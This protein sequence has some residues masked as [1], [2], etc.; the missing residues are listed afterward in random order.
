MNTIEETTLNAYVDGELEPDMQKQVLNA[1]E[2]DPQVR[3]QVCRLRRAKDWM[4]TGFAEVVPR[5]HRL[6]T[7]HR[8][9]PRCG[10]TIAASLLALAIGFGGGLL[11][12]MCAGDGTYAAA[13]RQDPNRVVLH[14]GDSDPTHFE[15]TL[16]YAEH[17]L[18]EN[19]ERGAR[20]EVVA[21]AGGID[22]VRSG[23]SPYED[24]IRA[25]RAR[26]PNLHFFACMN[27]IRNLRRSGVEPVFIDEVDTGS[28]AV[29]HIVRRLREG[30][31]YRKVEEV[32]ELQSL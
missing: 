9:W 13:A 7:A 1:M 31:T 15:A 12:Y 10:G 2:Q 18:A 25:L 11:G 23:V 8:R 28:T 30:W 14:L 3:E 26:Y 27:S 21:N 5:D 29:D 6:P 32:S 17:F 24:R 20:V 19:A 16:A 22:L 4:R